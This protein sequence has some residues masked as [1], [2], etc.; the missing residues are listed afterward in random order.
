MNFLTLQIILLVFTYVFLA[1]KDKRITITSELIN[2]GSELEQIK[3]KYH[4]MRL[5]ILEK[6][7]TEKARKFLKPKDFQKYI[8]TTNE[9]RAGRFVDKNTYRWW[10]DV[11]RKVGLDTYVY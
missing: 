1:K 11:R 2:K 4:R 10:C 9:K 7:G 6:E 5:E 3:A 8:R